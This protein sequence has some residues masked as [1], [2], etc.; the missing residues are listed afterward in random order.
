MIQ[1]EKNLNI[2]VED[3]GKGFDYATIKNAG[4]GL[5]N[6][7]KRVKHLWKS[8]FSF[9]E[10]C[11]EFD[12]VFFVRAKRKKIRYIKLDIQLNTLLIYLKVF[13]V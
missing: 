13:S 8:A 9:V 12:S 2:I 6:I 11:A 4:I 5:E 10:V 3:N 7:K 1:H